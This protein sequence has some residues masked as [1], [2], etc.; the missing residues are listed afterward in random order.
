MSTALILL[1]AAHTALAAGP[2]G[3]APETGR[4]KHAAIDYRHQLDFTAYTLPRRTWRIGFTHLDYGLWENVSI[5]TS[6]LLNIVAPNARLKVTAIQRGR[7]EASLQAGITRV[8][9]EI[10]GGAAADVTGLDIHAVPARWTLSWAP[11]ERWGLHLGNTWTVYRL[12][13]EVTGEALGNIMGTVIGSESGGDEIGGALGASTYAGADVVV[14]TLS[15]NT[16]VE[17]RLNR[18]D[19]IVLQSVNNVYV[20]GLLAATA[21]GGSEAVQAGVGVGAKIEVDPSKVLGTTTSIAWQWSWKRANLRLGI[22][23][24]KNPLG[25]VQAVQLYWL[26]GPVP[27]PTPLPERKR[28]G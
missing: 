1:F 15:S 6:P 10:L 3:A 23:L 9:S 21:G 22:P 8:N 11:H 5:G 26:L 14:N 25:F 17:Y 19:S 12:S 27:E 16:A 18:R 20:D 24:S 28:R 2:D 13:G 4:R 7:W